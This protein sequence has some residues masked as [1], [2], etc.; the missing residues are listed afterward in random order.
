MP[1]EEA[2]N[3]TP[4]D[5]LVGSWIPLWLRDLAPK[6]DGKEFDLNIYIKFNKQI[7]IKCISGCLCELYYIFNESLK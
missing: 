3:L 5:F 6:Q 1:L 4:F 2:R 7:L